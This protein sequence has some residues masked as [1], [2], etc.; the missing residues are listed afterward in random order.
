MVMGIGEHAV[1][2]PGND[3]V[4]GKSCRQAGGVR[5]ARAGDSLF[6]VLPGISGQVI[7]G[8]IRVTMAC[9][10][11]D[12]GTFFLTGTSFTGNAG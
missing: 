3:P 5:G 4:V 10:F 9:D 8:M 6:L 12:G 11:R 7:E 1:R 2:Y